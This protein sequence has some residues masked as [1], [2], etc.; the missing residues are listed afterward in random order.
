MVSKYVWL[1]FQDFDE[2]LLKSLNVFIPYNCQFFQ[3]KKDSFSKRILIEEVYYS[4]N[5][6]SAM[7]KRQY[8]SWEKRLEIFEPNFYERRRDL[9]GTNLFIYNF[10]ST[11]FYYN[12]S[13]LN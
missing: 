9:N 4:S 3:I 11:I 8:G 2:N 10:V 13:R 6:N 5:L 1:S 7:F 12:R